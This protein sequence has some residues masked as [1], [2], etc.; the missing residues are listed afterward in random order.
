MCRNPSLF[1][2]YR[3]TCAAEDPATDIEFP[4]TLRVTTKVKTP[5]LSLV[6][7]G[8]RTVSFLGLKVYSVAF[9]AD[10]NNPELKVFSSTI[11][12]T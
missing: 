11:P 7:V 5:L 3:L 12:R 4:T 6:G 10:L 1:C 2:F 9:Y 8:V